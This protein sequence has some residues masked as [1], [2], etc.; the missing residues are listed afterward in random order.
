MGNIF[1][2]LP[3]GTAEEE[4]TGLLRRPG[5]RIERIVSNGQAS[6][7]GFWYDQPHDEWVILLKGA[8]GLAIEGEAERRLK[9]GDYIFL[10]ARKR[11]RVTFTAADEP[12]VWLAVHI[13]EGHAAD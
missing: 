10:P 1:E 5:L 3:A 8:A 12:T 11:H 13:R 9:P 4:F 7:P 6:A 2:G